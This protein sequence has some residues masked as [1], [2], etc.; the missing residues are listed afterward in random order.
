MCSFTSLTFL[1][2]GCDSDDLIP[3]VIFDSL[4]NIRI[5][6]RVPLFVISKVGYTE[7]V[8]HLNLNHCSLTA[9][10]QNILIFNNNRY[11]V[12]PFR[13]EGQ[14]SGKNIEIGIIGNDKVF[15]QVFSCPQLR[16]WFF[17]IWAGWLISYWFI[18]LQSSHTSWNRRL[19]TRS[20][21]NSLHD[22][23]VDKI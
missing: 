8:M 20:W 16:G 9:L 7:I 1:V 5:K 14:I 15:R 18:S 6:T 12:Y 19:P 21:I 2:K 13:F 11:L 10:H 3:F 17:F 22:S 23:N 4:L